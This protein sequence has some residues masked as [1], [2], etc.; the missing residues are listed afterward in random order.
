MAG[1]ARAMNEIEALA[2]PY[3][4]NKYSEAANAAFDPFHVDIPPPSLVDALPNT[5]G[6]DTGR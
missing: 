1:H 6:G 5:T 4:A 3:N 2:N